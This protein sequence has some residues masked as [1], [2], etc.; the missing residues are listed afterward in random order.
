[1]AVPSAPDHHATSVTPEAGPAA[2]DMAC[3]PPDVSQVSVT[4]G[5]TWTGHGRAWTGMDR[6]S[7]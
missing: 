2:Y 6:I 7:I 3:R 4:R 5:T 1:M